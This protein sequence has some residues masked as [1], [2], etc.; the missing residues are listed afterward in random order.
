RVLD[1]AKSQTIGTDFIPL[2]N[3]KDFNNGTVNI[4]VQDYRYSLHPDFINNPTYAPY[5]A[6]NSKGG[7]IFHSNVPVTCDLP[8]PDMLM[9]FARGLRDKDLT[10]DVEAALIV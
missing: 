3:E 9:D 1:I 4:S 10:G 5:P 6:S 8:G 7:I 2:F